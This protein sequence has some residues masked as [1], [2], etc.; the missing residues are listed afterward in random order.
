VLKPPVGRL[1]DVGRDMAGAWLIVASEGL[2]DLG[3]IVRGLQAPP[4]RPSG[5]E[6][7]PGW[8][9]GCE[10]PRPL[11]GGGLPPVLA[12]AMFGRP[13]ST[14]QG[15]ALVAEA[16]WEPAFASEVGP[17]SLLALDGPLGRRALRVTRLLHGERPHG[18]GGT[19]PV[20]TFLLM[21]AESGE[22]R[23]LTATLDEPLTVAFEAPDTV[24]ADLAGGSE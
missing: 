8:R 10:T 14:P 13:R 20:V 22:P 21:D 6:L 3:C 18:F 15:S 12:E 5:M 7:P 9:G 16:T 4:P 23:S 1:L 19:V 24:P 2:E 17:G 11:D